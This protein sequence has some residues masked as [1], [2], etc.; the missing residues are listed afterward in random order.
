MEQYGFRK[1]R[2]TENAAYALIY[3][4][5]QAWNSKLQTVGTAESTPTYSGI[6]GHGYETEG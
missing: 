2:S 3:G 1:D 4:T 6:P 5:L